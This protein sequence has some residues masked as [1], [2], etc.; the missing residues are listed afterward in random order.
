MGAFLTT[1]LRFLSV[2]TGLW[3]LVLHAPPAAWSPY[4]DPSL[5]FSHPSLPDRSQPPPVTKLPGPAPEGSIDDLDTWL[6]KRAGLVA[7]PKLEIES[8][9]VNGLGWVT[10]GEP[11]SAI[12]PGQRLI[13]VPEH[14]WFSID[15]AAASPVFGQLMAQLPTILP[16]EYLAPREG[17][18]T[19][20]VYLMYELSRGQESPWAPYFATIPDEIDL[21][22]LW[23]S[24]TVSSLL[25]GSDVPTSIALW[26]DTR[27]PALYKRLIT[28]GLAVARPDFIA[29]SPESW[30]YA[31]FFRAWSI[32]S[33]RSFQVYK[34][35][36]DASKIHV[37]PKAAP[38]VD[39]EGCPVCSNPN[40]EADD[41]LA[42]EPHPDEPLRYMP[43]DDPKWETMSH[44]DMAKEIL[45]RLF[46]V[47]FFKSLWHRWLPD[48]LKRWLLTSRD[49][50]WE[51]FTPST[52]TLGSAQDAA[53]AAAALKAAQ[54]AGDE[55]ATLV[56]TPE[57]TVPSSKRTLDIAAEAILSA[58]AARE[59]AKPKSKVRSQRTSISEAESGGSRD[60]IVYT[61]LIPRVDLLNHNASA[62]PGL[63]RYWID[64][65]SPNRAHTVYLEVEERG[66]K[67]VIGGS[68]VWTSYGPRSNK[69]LLLHH[70]F[71]L[72]NNPFDTVLLH[73]PSYV[74]P[75]N[76]ALTE[77]RWAMLQAQG[78]DHP[79][80]WWISHN[81]PSMGLTDGR[82]GVDIEAA[83]GNV[84]LIEDALRSLSP[85]TPLKAAKLV[86]SP[87]A[88]LRA[89]RIAT[90]TWQ[91][92]TSLESIDALTNPSA[93]IEDGVVSDEAEARA[94]TALAFVASQQLDGY[95]TTLLQDLEALD[96]LQVTDLD[97]ARQASALNLVIGEKRLLHGFL[98]WAASRAASFTT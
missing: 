34:P 19:L 59:A 24:T 60:R 36:D 84:V 35:L 85:P 86:S 58:R 80:Y 4:Y 48:S 92:M 17:K 46:G 72:P 33:S 67:G 40:L 6:W 45:E 52:Y 75:D 55:E 77:R 44:Q 26:R 73:P 98:F 31:A 25:A 29:L 47:R 15:S 38:N 78:L 53:A 70:G 62:E 79:M 37:G 51:F 91:E 81:I 97:S 11:D 42:D 68:R 95:P 12:P 41:P 82:L 22:F 64:G 9:P 3:I 94:C 71:T 50:I 56:L 10:K 30:S 13:A 23:P 20:V 63:A 74:D 83:Q 5:L 54:D 43:W 21:P 8:D 39:D 16:H 2:L 14:L 27:L 18:Q 93:F 32:I 61:A 49:D 66:G 96:A 57:W 89:A 88:P 76:A 1:C 87:V 69:D 90:A 7:P 28:D 65:A